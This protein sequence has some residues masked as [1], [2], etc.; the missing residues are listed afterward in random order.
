[1]KELDDRPDYPKYYSEK[2]RA[3]LMAAAD[4]VQYRMRI[5]LSKEYW[6]H[7][8]KIPPNAK[9]PN[10]ILNVVMPQAEEVDDLAGEADPSNQ[11][12]YSSVP[13]LLHKYEMCLA[14]MSINCSSHCRYCY[15]SDLFNGISKKSK[16]DIDRIGSY[17]RTYNEMLRDAQSTHG[18]TH[19]GV[20]V[21]KHTRE[22]LLPIREIL[23]SGGDPLTLPSLTLARYMAVMAESGIKVIRIGTK[24]IVFNPGRFDEEFFAM[25]DKFHSMYPTTRIEFVGHYCH[26]YELVDA[27][28]NEEGEY[29]YGINEEYTLRKDLVEPLNRI[30]ARRGWLGHYNQFPIIAG[31]NDQPEIL[32]LLMQQS[33]R[34][35]ITIHN[36]YACR[37]IIGN[38]HFRQCNDIATQY[39][40]LEKA[41]VGLSG[42]EN[43]GRLVMSTEYGKIEVLGCVGTQIYMRLNRFLH[44]TAPQTA[45][46][47]IIVDTAK[48]DE[49]L[50]YWVDEKVI[51]SNAILQGRSVFDELKKLD[52][53]FVRGI[54]HAAAQYVMGQELDQTFPRQDPT[55]H[56]ES[57]GAAK[58]VHIEVH[59]VESDVQMTV[60][61]A[62]EKRDITLADILYRHGHVEAAC[63]CKLS[64]STCVGR[65]ESPSNVDPISQDELDVIDMVGESSDLR[66][67]CQIILQPGQQYA[68]RATQ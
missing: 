17:I 54:K 16:A 65:V 31:V 61:L 58:E 10:P 57:L 38:A 4:D 2:D 42:I 53:G 45:P 5:K 37:E 11:T 6:D 36:I 20:T 39:R 46:N 1:L 28:T 34:F 55:A 8:M 27:K 44:G 13:G 64:C 56:R 33:S 68:F 59:G 66:A 47:F 22:S 3:A 29:V 51:S 24:E 48:L 30:N 62:N 67:T 41:K 21:H 35:G 9:H 15:R 12:R 50:I 49:K 40:L 25:L 43:H 18:C 52:D 63:N 14:Y 19:D 26:P 32:R 23:F 60:D 7:C